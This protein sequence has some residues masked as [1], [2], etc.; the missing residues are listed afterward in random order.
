MKVLESVVEEMPKVR[1][2]GFQIEIRLE[3]CSSLFVNT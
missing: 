1:R 2:E 3:S